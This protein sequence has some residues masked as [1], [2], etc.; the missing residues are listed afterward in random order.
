MLRALL[1]VIVAGVVAVGVAVAAGNPVAGRKVFLTSGCGSCHTFKA[2]GTN[3]RVGPALTKARLAADAKK[4]EQPLAT[5]VR[6][7]VVRPKS[8]VAPGYPPVMP[9]FARLSK[10]QLDDLVAFVAKG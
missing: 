4:A 5:F 2:A 3:R 7:S 8:F 6:T 10:K 9:S 1:L